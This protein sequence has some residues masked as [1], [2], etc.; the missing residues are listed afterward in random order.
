MIQQEDRNTTGEE[1]STPHMQKRL[2]LVGHRDEKIGMWSN[3]PGSPYRLFRTVS[4]RKLGG[5]WERGYIMVESVK[6][7]A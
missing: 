6:R 2:Q 3:F 5:A 4:V 7:C 1:G